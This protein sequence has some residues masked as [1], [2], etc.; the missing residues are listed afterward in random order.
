MISTTAELLFRTVFS[1]SQLSVYGAVSDWCEELAQQISDHSSSSTERPVPEMDDESESRV[2]P[3]VVSIL[4][5]PHSIN[6][7]AQGDLLRSHSKTFETLPEDVRVSKARKDAGFM[8]KQFSW[9]LF[10][11]NP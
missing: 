8:I 11:D 10:H 1:V 5:N 6:V 9:T 4:T 2:S 7:P 3:N